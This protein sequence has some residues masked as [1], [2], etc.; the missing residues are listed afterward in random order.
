MINVQA[1][2][3]VTPQV[4]I[5]RRY[6]HTHTPCSACF[7]LWPECVLCRLSADPFSSSPCRSPPEGARTPNVTLSSDLHCP[8]IQRC[9]LQLVVSTSFILTGRVH[10]VAVH[11]ARG[12]D[13]FARVGLTLSGILLCVLEPVHGLIICVQA[14]GR[15]PRCEQV[16]FSKSSRK[17]ME[18]S[19]VGFCSL[20]FL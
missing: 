20:T 6:T 5:P 16:H 12:E 3:V 8:G 9:S 18:G 15:T 4:K 17:R 14:P 7:W 1:C 11:N 19:L 2:L 13:V 10:P